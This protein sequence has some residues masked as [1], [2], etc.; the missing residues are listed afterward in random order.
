[1]CET[2]EPIHFAIREYGVVNVFKWLKNNSILALD[3]NK[4]MGFALEV[5]RFGKQLQFLQAANIHYSQKEDSIDVPYLER[6]Q[7]LLKAISYKSRLVIVALSY[8]EIITKIINIDKK[9][10]SS[11]IYQVV[12]KQ[13]ERYAGSAAAD[14]IVD[15]EK[16][17]TQNITGN[18]IPIRWIAAKRNQVREIEIFC[19]QNGLRL[20][21]VDVDILA[22]QRSALQIFKPEHDQVV[23]IFHSTNESVLAC[24]CDN[25]Q[26]F[27]SH[28]EFLQKD[29]KLT[30]IILQLVKK[31]LTTLAVHLTI[32]VLLSG[33]NEEMELMKEELSAELSLDVLIAKPFGY[34]PCNSS[35]KK[36]LTDY[37]YMLCHGLAMRL[38]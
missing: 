14:L 3:I 21:A 10:T 36:D 35:F 12:Q 34:Y 33:K 24:L 18:L 17:P 16:I 29:A 26:I 4:D 30:E 28:R 25:Y 20:L 15:Y 5:A 22:L 11:Q 2:L 37:S 9:L 27:Y 7:L 8:E 32:K 23:L 38:D 6:L 31:I 19:K 1:M 13:A